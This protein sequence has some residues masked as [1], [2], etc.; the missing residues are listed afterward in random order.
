M[1]GLYIT[2]QHLAWMYHHQKRYSCKISNQ[3][4]NLSKF[5]AKNVYEMMM[6]V[7]LGLINLRRTESGYN[8]ITPPKL[9]KGPSL[10]LTSQFHRYPLGITKFR[11]NKLHI[12][13]YSS[14]WQAYQLLNKTNLPCTGIELIQKLQ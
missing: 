10:I 4:L 13:Y 2:R 3:C 6:Q 12:T 11:F 14:K 9:T 8:F 5:I 7:R 1:P